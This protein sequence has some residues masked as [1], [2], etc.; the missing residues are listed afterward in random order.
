VPTLGDWCALFFQPGIDPPEIAVAH[1]DPARMDWA[2]ELTTR[3]PYDPEAPT[4]AAAVIRTGVPEFWPAIDE[5]LL[6]LAV[7]RSPVP[8]DE[9]REVIRRL[10][11]TSVIT[12]PLRV[13]RGVIGAMTFVSAESRRRY[14]EA[15]FALAE[16]AAGRVA[17]ALEGL[18]VADTDREVATKLQ[19][20]LLPS[21]LPTSPASR[22]LPGTGPQA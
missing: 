4:G 1:A 15:D 17:A 22:W 14:D 6:D 9:L 3:Y 12:V 16:A 10:Q 13:R 19:R 11:L 2:R 18:W 8:E 5:S 7:E 21:T 20:A